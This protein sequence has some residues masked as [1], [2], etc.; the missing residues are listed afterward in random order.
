MILNYFEGIISWIFEEF[1]V[2]EEETSQI[3]FF[4]IH[5]SV[6]CL[7]DGGIY[8]GEGV[9]TKLYSHYDTYDQDLD[10]KYTHWALCCH[11]QGSG[12]P[13][14]ERGNHIFKQNVERHDILDIHN[15]LIPL[16]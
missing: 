6:G 14:I 2:S 9:R 13:G 15:N 8:Y 10:M 12:Q 16:L 3:I 7:G 11:H 1:V 4:L 5:E